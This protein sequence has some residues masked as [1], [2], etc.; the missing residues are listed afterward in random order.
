[1]EKRDRLSATL[2]MFAWSILPMTLPLLVLGFS[3]VF[4]AKSY[5]N[6]EIADLAV[7]QLEYLRDSLELSLY[8][9]DALNLTLSSNKTVV[10]SVDNL[11]GSRSMDLA[12]IATARWLSDS[13]NAQINARTYIDSV[14]FYLDKY[15]DRFLSTMDGIVRT[16]AFS[17]TAWIGTYRRIPQDKPIFSEVR[18]IPK[19]QPDQGSKTFLTLYRRIYPVPGS[20]RAGVIVMNMLESFFDRLLD[21]AA[22]FSGQR[23]FLLDDAGNLIKG[24][25][26]FDPEAVAAYPVDS[27]TLAAAG[28]DYVYSTRT[29]RYGWRVVS[30]IPRKSFNRMPA[31]IQYLIYAV[32]AGSLLT[33]AL[34]AFLVAKRRARRVAAVVDLFRKADLGEDLPEHPEEGHDEYDYL[35]GTLIRTFLKQRYATLQLSERQAKAEVLELRA[36]KAQM[37]PHFLFNTLDALYWMLYGQAGV[38]SPAARAVE[39]LSSLLRYSLERGDQ[40]PFR[41][42]IEA[43]ERYLSIH[44]LRYGDGLGVSW[45]IAEGAGDCLV[46]KLILQPLVENS[47]QHAFGSN[48]E[49]RNLSIESAFSDDG[50]SLR[51]RVED[52]G[53]GMTEERLAEARSSLSSDVPPSEHIGLQNTNRRIRLLYGGDYGISISPILPRGTQVEILLPVRLQAG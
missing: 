28:A 43:T 18:P 5:M 29:D 44:R 11:F 51:I 26:Y 53:E 17:D 1:M 38:P 42:E 34:L 39:D 2:R 30:A 20:Q 8:E 23:I 27:P 50:R 31:A 15:P 22:L 9:L 46:P 14:Y 25:G 24:I 36:L 40:V 21:R 4:V 6:R 19:A 49:R 16:D 47:L 33:G 48:S 41:S 35:V 13:F 52:D 12:D 3:A 32:L 10:A 7:K 37:N 45:R